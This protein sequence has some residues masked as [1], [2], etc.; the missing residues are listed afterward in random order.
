MGRKPRTGHETSE[1]L[2]MDHPE[3]PFSLTL[4]RAVL[5]L[6]AAVDLTGIDDSGHSHRVALMTATVAEHLGWGA[7]ER[8]GLLHAALL[9]DCGVSSTRD[10][11]H[12]IDTLEWDNGRAHCERG[13][14]VVAA[15][16]SLAHL[17]P[18]ILEHHSRWPDLERRHVAPEVARQANL[19]A[20][21]D[22]A[23]YLR[24]RGI[25]PGRA[26]T[27]IL[28]GSS[29]THF[30]PHLL[31]AFREMADCEAFWF[32]QEAT[33]LTERIEELAAKGEHHILD[34]A[35]IKTLANVFGQVIDAKS[36]YTLHHSA[37]VGRLSRWLGSRLD[38][39]EATLDMLEIAGLL[40]D[41]GKLRIPDELVERRGP[42]SAEERLRVAR[43]PFDTWRIL[44]QMFG[45][46]PVAEWAA[47]HH[48]ALSGHG[49]PFHRDANSLS[50]ESRIVAVAD[51]FQAMAQGRPYRPA[52]GPAE[53]VPV[54]DGLVF[55]GRLDSTVVAVVAADSEAAWR[56]AMT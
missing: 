45:A 7:R 3:S 17:A 52:M 40:H 49:Y 18:L 42:L 16:P 29:R 25:G 43:H 50:L 37:G 13:A 12:L 38:L 9:H 21:A 56:E 33:S 24:C 31:S 48:E 5:A 11:R 20:L 35:A 32:A 22:C 41:L 47:F 53:I 26:V 19:I 34:A 2:A 51:V 14:E 46:S 44:R 54:L 1:V 27:D 39:A 28:A 6:A 15:I 4:D 23:D 30:A 36:P 10:H 8:H 55:G